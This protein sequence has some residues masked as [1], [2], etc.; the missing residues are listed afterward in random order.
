M[1]AYPYFQLTEDNS[2]DTANATFYDA[3]D[4]TIGASQG[5]VILLHVNSLH[6]T[7]TLSAKLY[8]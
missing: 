3:L 4:A 6:R 2:I 8:G 5:Q 1:D 7:N